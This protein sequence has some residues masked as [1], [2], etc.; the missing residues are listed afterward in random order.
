MGTLQLCFAQSPTPQPTRK[1]KGEEDETNNLWYLGVILGLLG[2]IAINTGNNLQSMGMQHLEMDAIEEADNDPLN[3]VARIRKVTES[4][5]NEE[6]ERFN[7][8]EDIPP[9]NSCES[10]TWKVGTTIFVSGSLL[11]FASYGFAAQSLLA[12]LE[13]IQFVTNLAFGKFMLG[14]DVT[15]RQVAGT[16]V[17]VGGTILTV[18]FSSKE[19]LELG[20]K[21]M[22]ALYGKTPFLVYLAAVVVALFVLHYTH[23]YFQKMEDQKTPLPHS[24]VVL[25]STYATW[26]ALFGTTSV[27]QAKCLAE[28]L[29]AQ[30]SGHE[31]IFQHWFTYACLLAWLAL[32]AVWLYRMNEALSKYNPI[33]IIPLLQVNF[34]LFA[35][36]SG[37]IFFEEFQTFTTSMWIGFWCGVATIFFGLY[38]LVPEDGEDQEI[39]F[40]KATEERIS[41]ASTRG[42]FTEHRSVSENFARLPSAR[43]SRGTAS[44]S[45]RMSLSDHVDNLSMAQRRGS[46]LVLGSSER[47]FSFVVPHTTS[48]ASAGTAN[49]TRRASVQFQEARDSQLRRQLE[50]KT[51][52]AQSSAES[53]QSSASESEDEL[54]PPAG[55]EKEST[56]RNPNKVAPMPHKT[57]Q[58]IDELE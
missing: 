8:D 12:C 42:S 48:L 2:S 16:V 17:I 18:M 35:I 13:A 38:L 19:S 1:E 54:R 30:L 55:N 23:E 33:F 41:G 4:P 21:D 50:M 5:I 37:G 29:A 45:R 51:R 25:Q 3:A 46:F 44:E 56:G 26:S 39:Q 10:T 43:F 58:Q 6:G 27:V 32:T 7:V 57:Q 15:Q 53:E 20:T 34:I 11:N 36:V 47:G 49:R 24:N 22:L 31:Q 28:L 14:T 9:V 40:S 52:R